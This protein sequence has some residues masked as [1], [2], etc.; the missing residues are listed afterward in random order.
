M[1]VIDNG[2]IGS[3][4][5][6]IFLVLGLFF[7]F[8]NLGAMCPQ[9]VGPTI[10]GEGQWNV[11]TRVGAATNIIESQ[12][13]AL[14]LALTDLS[15]S[16]TFGQANIGDG[17]IYTISVPGTYCMTENVTF[18]FGTA[19]TINANNVTVDLEGYVLS[20]ADNPDTIGIA[21][22]LGVRD[23][24]IHNGIIEHLAGAFP[25]GGI[26]IIDQ[27]FTM[28]QTLRN[29]TI[30]DMSFN[31]NSVSAISLNGSSS[32]SIY[33]VE[34]LLIENCS[35]YNSGG[36]SVQ[37]AS[38]IVQ[39][40]ELYAS[41]GVPSNI[42]LNGPSLA[43]DATSFLI[44]D[45]ILTSSFGNSSTGIVMNH[46]E[47]GII[48]NCI[49]Q[50]SS[51]EGIFLDAFSNM[52]IADCVIQSPKNYGMFIFDSNAGAILTIERCVVNAAGAGSGLISAYDGLHIE[53]NSS[54]SSFASLTVVDC[55]AQSNN[56][57]GFWFQ[58]DTQNWGN[59]TVKGCSAL[60]NGSSGFAV[61]IAA[62][63]ISLFDTVFEDCVAQRNVGDGFALLN[64]GSES[65]IQ[66]VVFRNCVA[67][68]NSANLPASFHGD[69]FGIGSSTANVGPILNVSC[70]N[71]VAQQNANDGFN[72]GAAASKVD[73]G[74]CQYCTA[75]N[76]ASHGM[77]FS[78]TS[79]NCQVYMSLMTN[80]GGNGINNLNP[81]FGP[82]SANRFI[83]NRSFRN[84]GVDYFQINDG[85]NG[86]PFFSSSDETLVQGAS[87]WANLST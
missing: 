40:C 74:S 7:S 27:P 50:G 2:G 22:G 65:F 14:S 80:N 28:N 70:Q 17:G 20:G 31:N 87:P 85:V 44:Q 18:T 47:N 68:A 54:L 67:Q 38:A 63:L 60:G 77:N 41:N 64:I 6:Q 25:I 13:C 15:C 61:V 12:L 48:R 37:G 57:A 8:P 5:K 4:K 30:Q 32:A 45:C 29:I 19:I 55:I 76:N 35:L 3:I 34:D 49:S 66:N 51:A 11:L 56:G 1:G 58:N 72:F 71:C 59:I 62:N 43:P 81:I 9:T 78:S 33:D 79:T 10:P 16:F 52:V 82:S 69:G 26:G 84:G 36:I 86:Q 46:V 42:S 21:L 53:T 83:A 23:V 75:E 39:G 73:T 24:I